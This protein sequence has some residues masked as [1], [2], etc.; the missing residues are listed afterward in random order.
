MKV[1]LWVVLGCLVTVA[2]V[3]RANSADTPERSKQAAAIAEQIRKVLPDGWKVEQNYAHIRVEYEKPVRGIELYPPRA[4]CVPL[5]LTEPKE[6]DLKFIFHFS[7][8]DRVDPK[9]YLLE[10][11]AIIA[12]QGFLG[13]KIDK[14]PHESGKRPLA[15][16]VFQCRNEQEQQD[17]DRYR[18]VSRRLDDFPDLYTESCG[19]VLSPSYLSPSSE[20]DRDYLNAHYRRV[21]ALFNV[22]EGREQPKEEDAPKRPIDESRVTG[23]FFLLNKTSRRTLGPFDYEPAGSVL[24]GSDAYEIQM[25]RSADQLTKDKLR[26]TVI[27]EVEFHQAVIYDVVE[28]LQQMSVEYGER[29]R[30]WERQFEGVPRSLYVN[31]RK[32]VIEATSEQPPKMVGSS[33]TNSAKTVE[34]TLPEIPLIDFQAKNISLYDALVAVCE[35]GGLRFEIKD[36]KVRF[37]RKDLKAK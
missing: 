31:Y 21:M 3:Y 4:I 9:L 2:C 1:V 30:K 22:Y 15:K 5:R 36:G 17:V 25:N 32:P 13:A 11:K 20:R 18:V 34:Q 6:E 24:I 19:L 16:D 37:D 10:K 26:N 8:T 7:I 14:I 23:S 35:K 33:P 28:A 27:P 29:V 12:E